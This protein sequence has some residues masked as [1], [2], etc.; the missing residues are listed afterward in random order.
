MTSFIIT[1]DVTDVYFTVAISAGNH[2]SA[3][4]HL[5]SQIR[6]TY[7][8]KLETLL[9]ISLLEVF[10]KKIMGTFMTSW[11]FWPHFYRNMARVFY[12]LITRNTV[13]VGMFTRR[14]YVTLIPQFIADRLCR[15]DGGDLFGV[16][17]PS[18][19]PSPPP[20]PTASH[21]A[22]V[23]INHSG[24]GRESTQT[25]TKHLIIQ[26]IRPINIHTLFHRVFQ[27]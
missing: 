1:C 7:K 22:P 9:T 6:E 8:E 13:H 10:Y 16:R 18:P 25:A 3:H 11:N 14:N 2:L 24:A 23:T 26:I 4:N 5:I 15:L 17:S 19:T 12:I 27:T 21:V 20:T